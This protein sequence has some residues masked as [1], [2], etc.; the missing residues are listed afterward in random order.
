[1]W[2][3]KKGGGEG[4]ARNDIIVLAE[5]KREHLRL[6]SFASALS[7]R[8]FDCDLCELERSVLRK[9]LTGGTPQHVSFNR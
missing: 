5:Q 7:F 9:E 1:M 2:K 6:V 8:L 3:G 4:S